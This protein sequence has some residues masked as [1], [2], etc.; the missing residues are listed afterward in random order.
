MKGFYI[1]AL[2]PL[3]LLAG[4]GYHFPSR[5]GG[6]LAVYGE[7]ITIPIFA[8]KTQKANLEIL[9]A[10]ELLDEF[11]RKRGVKVIDT[12]GGDLRLSGTITSYGTAAVSYSATDTVKEYRAT[13]AVGAVLKSNRDGK[14]IWKG[15]VS[16]SQDFPA[17][18][19]I[20]LQRNSEDAAI[21]EILGKVAQELYLNIT[22]DF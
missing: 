19:D 4:C 5:D 3:F 20:A 8:N 18:T 13:M 1:F 10:N 2:L 17:N 15:T 16:R 12:E 6:P 14:V 7:S 21:R 9:L 11:H 22:N